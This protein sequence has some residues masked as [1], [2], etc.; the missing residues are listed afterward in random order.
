[1]GVNEF[2][3][4][5]AEALAE[6]GLNDTLWGNQVY[7]KREMWASAYLWNKFCA[8]F[9]T[10][11]RCEGINSMVKKFLQSKH[12]MLEL[13]QNLELLLWEFRNNELLSQFRLIYGDPVLTTSLDSLEWF[14]ARVYTR[15]V[16]NDVKKELEAAA[17]INFVGG[18]QLLTTK[19][20]TVDE[21]GHPGRPIVVLCDKNMGRL[22]CDCYFW[23]THRY[24]CKHMFF[25]MK[26]EH[27]MEVQKCLVLKRWTKDAKH[28]GEYVEKNMMM[29]TGSF[30]FVRGHC[31]L[32]LIGY[33]FLGY[34]NSVYSRRR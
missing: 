11:S 28:V 19:V 3:T 25:V 20:Y 14:A 17:F 13:V 30:C 26:H 27:V 22:Q 24:P 1:M 29:V 8:G 2:E 23:D 31:I 18:R 34:N 4:E 10:T 9:R 7:G 5:W 32:R 6:Y 16:F 15:T 33:F 21:F 12:T